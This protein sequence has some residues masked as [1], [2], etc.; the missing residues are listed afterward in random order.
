MRAPLLKP[1][2]LHA[3]AAQGLGSLYTW[4]EMQHRKGEANGCA[5]VACKKRISKPITFALG[6]PGFLSPYQI[7][8][9][10][11]PAIELAI[12]EQACCVS[13]HSP[14]IYYTRYI[15]V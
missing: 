12:K 6:L 2:L 3:G 10:C 11:R 8:S 9:P 7:N 4:F 5:F 15:L 14:T 1:A 13:Y